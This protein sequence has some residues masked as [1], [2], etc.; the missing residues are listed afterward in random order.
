MSLKNNT[1][2]FQTYVQSNRQMSSF[3]DI[4]HRELLRE[5]A[6]NKEMVI[7]AGSINRNR[8]TGFTKNR[9]P[10]R[11]DRAKDS[12]AMQMKHFLRQIDAQYIHIFRPAIRFE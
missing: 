2:Y 6:R 7:Y 4:C 3:M 9:L 5:I 11:A 12:P 10:Y 8:F 1:F